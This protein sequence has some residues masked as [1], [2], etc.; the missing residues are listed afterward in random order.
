M[1]KPN[2]PLPPRLLCNEPDSFSNYTAVYRWPAT[3]QKVIDDNALSHTAIEQLKQLK[4]DIN[5]GTI[6]PLPD[7]DTW[8]QYLAPYIGQ[9]WLDCPNFFAETYL[10][11]RIMHAIAYF[12]DGSNSS[13]SLDPFANEKQLGLLSTQS[14][15][16]Q[17]CQQLNNAL[18]QPN[19]TALSRF[20]LTCLWG[21]RA[22][23]S[24]FDVGEEEA[25]AIVKSGREQLLADE[26][27]AVMYHLSQNH[28]I[29]FI[30]DN[31]GFELICDLA[32]TDYLLSSNIASSIHLHLKEHPT[33]VS[34][35]TRV[36]LAQTIS[37]LLADIDSQ[38]KE[39]ATRLHE[40]GKNGRLQLHDHPFWT[41]PLDL[42]KMP[43]DLRH[44]LTQSHLIISKGDANYRR[45]LG[46]RHWPFN[47]PFADIV[48]YMP[49]PLL[50][51]RTA[52]S[53]LMVGISQK[54]VDEVT[55]I[56]ENWLIN[57]RWGVIQFA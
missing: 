9:S 3:V 40:Y 50:A 43:T 8:N 23:L 13:S 37:F 28:R 45:I 48:T 41:S 18:E 33:F 30:I 53:E 7:T 4:D 47:T 1:T 22:D 44:E 52:K 57:G 29:D 38:V 15:I 42:W 10:Y 55:K 14:A 49:A 54:Q 34:D 19:Q 24:L 32:L 46:D 20:I 21:N 17:L 16:R 6:R 5:H 36:D 26:T 39:V 11:R 2:L 31:A 56:D 27:T 25:K 51:L 12:A 35:A